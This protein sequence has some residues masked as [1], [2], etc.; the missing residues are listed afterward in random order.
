MCV[1]G[2]IADLSLFVLGS[3]LEKR[4]MMMMMGVIAPR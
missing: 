4:V 2:V 3:L 1:L